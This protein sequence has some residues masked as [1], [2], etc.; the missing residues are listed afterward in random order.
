V[1]LFI[2]G[3]AINRNIVGPIR[4]LR[5]AV[6]QAGR[7]IVPAPL[8]PEGP[9]EIAHL[10]QEFNSMVA[11]RAEYEKR[12]AFEALNDQLTGLPNRT[13]FVDR[14]ER[15]LERAKRTGESTGVLV[16]DL[17]RFYV[18]NDGLGHAGADA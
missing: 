7:D 12:L 13:L 3:L 9:L 16:I 5:T 18:V 1:V 2:L 10:V 14:A 15:A 4:R 8:I 6:E 17:D 11:S